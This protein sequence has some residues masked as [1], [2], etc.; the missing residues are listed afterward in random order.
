VKTTQRNKEEPPLR[1]AVPVNVDV[2][3]K[4]MPLKMLKQLKGNLSRKPAL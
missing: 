4:K 2:D 1:V 3:Q